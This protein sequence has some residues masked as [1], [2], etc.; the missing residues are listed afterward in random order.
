MEAYNRKQGHCKYPSCCGAYSGAL[1]V[2]WKLFP[3]LIDC[4]LIINYRNLYF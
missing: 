4:K 3:L 1:L 2:Q